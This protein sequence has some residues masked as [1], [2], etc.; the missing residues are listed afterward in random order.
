MYLAMEHGEKCLYVSTKELEELRRLRS[1]PGAMGD[2]TFVVGGEAVALHAV[3]VVHSPLL[4]QPEVFHHEHDHG[5]HDGMG[6]DA[7]AEL[8]LVAGAVLVLVIAAIELRAIV[9][10]IRR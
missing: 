8:V 5:D 4:D 6:E 1:M 2:P 7:G 3:K 9:R 10:R